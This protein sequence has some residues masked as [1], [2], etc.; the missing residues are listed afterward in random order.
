MMAVT[1]LQ[2]ISHAKVHIVDGINA[3]VANVSSMEVA[4]VTNMTIDRPMP[5]ANEVVAASNGHRQ[6][7]GNRN[8]DCCQVMFSEGVPGVC[9][10]AFTVQRISARDSADKNPVRG[11]HLL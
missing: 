7:S 2:I 4:V 9:M 11:V 6:N 10:V 3:R 5:M 8:V 1:V